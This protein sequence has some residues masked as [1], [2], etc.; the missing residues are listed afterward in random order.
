MNPKQN[1]NFEVSDKADTP[2]WVNNKS[3][4]LRLGRSC[5]ECVFYSFDWV[6]QRGC[7]SGM[8][9]RAHAYFETT[10]KHCL[11]VFTG[12][13]FSQGFLGGAKWISSIHTITLSL[14]L[15]LKVNRVLP[16]FFKQAIKSQNPR[17]VCW[18]MTSLG[19]TSTG[20]LVQSILQQAMIGID[21]VV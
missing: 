21:S 3:H 11:L 19:S 12:Q 8:A 17:A 16:H 14:L 10:A 5:V 13:S 18:C 9:E 2:K 20:W 1:H 15:E 4:G 6:A 7:T